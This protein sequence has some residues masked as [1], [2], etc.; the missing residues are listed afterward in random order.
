MRNILIF[1]SKYNSLFVFLILQLVC[2]HLIIN[3][4]NKQ[5]EI[6]L[7]SYNLIAGEVLSRYSK[8]LDYLELKDINSRLTEE[9]ALLIE[10]FYNRK[11]KQIP[12]YKGND[13]I[14]DYYKVI[15]AIVCNNSI[16]KRNNRITIDRGKNDGIEKGMGVIGNKGVIGTV[17]AVN[18][19]FASIIPLH[20][21]VSR[22]SAMIKNKEYFGILR[23]E[24]YDYRKSVLTTI[25]KHADVSIGDSIITSG[26]SAIFPKGIFIGTID[27][28]DVQQGSNYFEIS[29]NLVNDLYRLHEV[30]IIADKRIEERSE[31]EKDHDKN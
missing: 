14:A 11:Y 27:K 31:I 30:Y 20:N 5:K 4:N 26:F 23:W 17:S 7:Y 29:I 16:S 13:S 15:P 18:Q 6:F 22:T 10:N 8:T 21:T 9:N 1:I 24:P 2:L 19:N 3:Y 28:I 25:P 12:D